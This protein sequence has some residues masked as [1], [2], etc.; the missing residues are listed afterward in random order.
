MWQAGAGT[1]TPRHGEANTKNVDVGTR[2][3]RPRR[4]APQSC[5]SEKAAQP[6]EPV[7]QPFGRDVHPAQ[8]L[9]LHG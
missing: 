6:E 7:R 8:H 3:P 5:W 9:A 4:H 2:D 1:G